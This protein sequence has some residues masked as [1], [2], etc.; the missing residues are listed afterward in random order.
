MSW[1]IRIY[2]FVLLGYTAWRTY[3]FM[4]QQLPDGS[5]TFIAL[6]FLFAT[7][8]GL[9]LW[10]EV[11][12]RHTTTEIQHT[13]AIAMVIVDFVASL[14]AGVADM[15]IRQTLVSEYVVP[16]LL[17]GLLIYGLPIVVAMN[18]A[19]VILFTM[20]D[21][22]TQIKMATR[23]VE[24]KIHKNALD[25]LAANADGIS[26]LVQSEIARKLGENIVSGTAGRYQLAPPST[27][28]KPKRTK[29]MASVRNNGHSQP[30]ISEEDINFYSPQ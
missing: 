26:L 25:E 20:N 28:E 23:R 14:G 6:L 3:D 30:A 19:A 10:H 22:D 11:S 16:P 4:M 2:A 5:G 27:D 17:A 7:E 29:V 21:A 12:I 1:I 24:Y 8:I 15:I 18:V 13:I 9:V